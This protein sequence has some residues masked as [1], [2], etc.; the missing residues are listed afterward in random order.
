M[1]NI[2]GSIE[3]GTVAPADVKQPIHG[4]AFDR[5]ITVLCLWFLGGLYLDGWA[6]NH[7]PSALES[8]F[9]PWHGVFYSGFLATAAYLWLG[10]IVMA[11]AVGLLLSHLV[12]PPALPAQTTTPS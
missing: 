10:A 3:V 9:T 12:L 1:A 4:L 8:F 6:H 2:A 7:L 5:T 11:N